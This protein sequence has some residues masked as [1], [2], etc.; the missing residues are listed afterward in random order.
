[1]LRAVRPVRVAQRFPV[2]RRAEGEGEAKAAPKKKKE[3]KPQVGPARNSTVR[4]RCGAAARA[5]RE[6]AIR[7]W[8]STSRISCAEPP[9]SRASLPAA[10]SGRAL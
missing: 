2:A 1:M 7:R 9:S 3:E 8:C 4:S 6:K 5:H 10:C